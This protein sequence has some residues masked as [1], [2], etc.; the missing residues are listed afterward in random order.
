MP[1][2]F[3][4]SEFFLRFV[5][6]RCLKKFSFLLTTGGFITESNIMKRQQV[7]FN[8]MEEYMSDEVR[9]CY[10]NYFTRYAEYFSSASPTTDEGLKVLSDPRIYEIFD[11]ASL[12]IYPSTVY[13]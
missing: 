6:P 12:D 7:H 4:F 10:G 1:N 8:E 2:I 13:R 9:Q 3:Y 5:I 11:N